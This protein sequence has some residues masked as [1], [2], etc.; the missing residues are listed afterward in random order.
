MLPLHDV[1]DAEAFASAVIDRSNLS[2]RWHERED[3]LA[4]LLATAWELSLAFDPG[5]GASFSAFAGA[6]LRRHV[7][8]WQR[9]RFGRTVWKFRDRVHE[10]PRTVVVSLD[11][12]GLVES[13][14]ARRGDP[15]TDRSPD[16]GRLLAGGG[17]ERARDLATLGLG[18][19]RRA[20]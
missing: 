13:L 9:K 17:R 19:A 11:E 14:A 1:R 10:R 3:L 16:L 6:A 8:D 2:L 15:Q 4:Y 12:P 7:V 18:A 5:R 20:R